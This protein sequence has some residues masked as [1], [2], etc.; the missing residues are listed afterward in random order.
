MSTGGAHSDPLRPPGPAPAPSE[1]EA[2]YETPRG[3]LSLWVGVLGGAVA[4]AV[5]FQIGYALSRFSHEHRWLTGVHHAVSAVAVLLAVGAT[6]LAL[7]DWRRLGGGEPHGTEEGVAGRSRFLAVLGIVTS[8]LF[9]L[10][11]VGQ[12][13]P[14]FFLDPGW[15]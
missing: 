3:K 15:Y 8:G 11:I 13:V 12:W 10:V 4:W 6:L 1:A 14:V 9:A 7:R 2:Y 5:Q